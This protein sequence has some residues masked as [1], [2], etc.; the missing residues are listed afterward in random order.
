MEIGL[1]DNI[2][3]TGFYWVRITTNYG[4]EWTIGEFNGGNWQLLGTDEIYETNEFAEIGSR[5]ERNE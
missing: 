4:D 2:M 3:H 1:R 5:I